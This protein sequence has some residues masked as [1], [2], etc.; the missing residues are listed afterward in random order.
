MITIT[1][2]TLPASITYGTP[3]NATLAFT[4]TSPA[5]DPTD[6]VV[7]SAQR[8]DITLPTPPPTIP[9]LTVSPFVF[10]V[11][12][13]AQPGQGPLASLTLKFAVGVAEYSAT[14]SAP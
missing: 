4:S 1:K 2:V 5:T 3:F 13:T 7:S 12:V 8:V 6:I 10:R 9:D 14:T 11:T